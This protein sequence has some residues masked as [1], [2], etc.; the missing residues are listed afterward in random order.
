[1]CKKKRPGCILVSGLMLLVI[2][3][4]VLSEQSRITNKG[5]ISFSRISPEI[6]VQEILNAHN[7]Y[8]HALRLA[9]LSW[10]EDIS[11]AAR[12]WAVHLAGTGTM[13]HSSSRYGE[14]IWAGTSGAYSQ[15]EMINAW[16]SEKR[17]FVYGQRFPDIC[18]GHWMKCGHYTQMIWRNTRRVGCGTAS[19]A[20]MTYLV[21][22]YD[23]P[24]NFQGQ[25]PY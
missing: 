18:K 17:F 7:H 12:K 11:M 25:M 2:S 22:Q 13:E 5:G 23:P 3:S 20:D 6:D 4:Q 14:N 21:C 1:M 8:R 19:R 24:G 10:S 9:N 15:T 16:G